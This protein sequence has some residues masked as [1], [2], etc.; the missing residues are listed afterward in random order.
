MRDKSPRFLLRDWHRGSINDC[1]L[2][3]LSK[4]DLF[5]SLELLIRRRLKWLPQKQCNCSNRN[6]V[7]FKPIIWFISLLCFWE[8]KISLVISSYIF[9]F[10]SSLWTHQSIQEPSHN[11]LF[12]DL[13]FTSCILSLFLWL[14]PPSC[15]LLIQSLQPYFICLQPNSWRIAFEAS[16][17]LLLS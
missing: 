10:H 5:R 8:L 4:S 2:L 11:K 13:I 15:F 17:L 3:S 6:D 9:H 16:F 14:L 12:I 1:F 7:L